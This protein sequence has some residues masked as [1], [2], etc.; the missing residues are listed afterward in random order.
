MIIIGILLLCGGGGLAIYGNSLNNSFEAR[1]ESLWTN[2]STDPG[3]TYIILGIVLAVLGLV[4][5]LYGL[6]KSTNE[7][8]A[9]DTQSNQSATLHPTQKNNISSD[10]IFV[11]VDGYYQCRTCG[12]R[13]ILT[14]SGKCLNCGED[15]AQF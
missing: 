13:Q 6:F 3:S 4:L 9:S 11:K 12:N 15:L 1:W 7:N 5:L 2:G 8:N 10:E 14:N